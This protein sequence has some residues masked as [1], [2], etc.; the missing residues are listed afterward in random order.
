[1]SHFLPWQE[2]VFVLDKSDRYCLLSGLGYNHLQREMFT[3]LA[4]GAALF[5]PSGAEL[6]E[7]RQLAR[8]LAQNEITVLHMTPALGRLLCTAGEKLPAARRIFF[9]GDAL[10]RS[11]LAAMRQC[12]PNARI[13]SF[14]GATETQ[15]AVGYHEISP[16]DGDDDQRAPNI[17]IG[18]G[19]KDVQL[20]LLTAHR[21]MAGVGELAELYIRSPHLAAGYLH[22]DELTA[23]NFLANPF[24]PSSAD[25]GDRLYRSGELGRYN[26]DG[27]VEWVGRGERRANIRGFRVELAEVE[28]ALRRHPS[29]GQVA[30]VAKAAPPLDGASH[31]TSEQRLVA[32]VEAAV[33]QTI[34]GA[35][36]GD[37]LMGQLPHYM[38]PAHFHLVQA[39]PLGPNG[40]VDYAKLA[41]QDEMAELASNSEAGFEA[42]RP[43]VEARL[44]E[45][46]RQVLGVARIGRG[47]NFF[48]LGGHSLLVAQAAARIRQAFGVG[49][50]LRAL[51]E[52]PTVEAL[53]Q[54]VELL[55][56][57]P[58]TA[59]EEIEL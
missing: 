27:D 4:A 41:A 18:K 22:D 56:G 55:R 23:A 9:G 39:L 28:A 52:A 30:V 48:H 37:F 2:E 38:V 19:A 31:D 42:P 43:G 32:Y 21:Q 47:D 59:R 5:V 29:V 51:F 53:A 45:I 20:L 7:P 57:L 8:W 26:L 12:A 24:M 36:L 46:F 17:P 49:L 10:T 16:H 58:A 1:M 11:D 15:R 14:Y 50:D 13:V 54:R 40:K 25:H 34:Y 3:A 6:K 44:A 33:D 35:E